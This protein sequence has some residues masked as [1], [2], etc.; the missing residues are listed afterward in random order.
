MLRWFAQTPIIQTHIEWPVSLSIDPIAEKLYW[1]DSK[2]KSISCADFQGRKRKVVHVFSDLRPHFIAIFGDFIFVTL[3][4]S[5]G[6]VRINKFSNFF[7][8]KAQPN[9]LL[10]RGLPISTRFSPTNHFEWIIRSL[11][12]PSPILILHPSMPQNKSHNCEWCT[13][14][15]SS[16]FCFYSND[17]TSCL[18][19]NN[20]E[21]PEK[22]MI[23]CPCNGVSCSG[24]E[25]CQNGVCICG[26]ACMEQK[27]CGGFNCTNGEVC[28]NG[29]CVCDDSCSDQKPV[30][31]VGVSALLGVLLTVLVV[32]F[33]WAYCFR[34]NS[35]GRRFV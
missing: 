11:S 14:S 24:A 4:R 16:G 1:S 15:S 6:V 21:Y 10:L 7:F 3:Y 31:A 5:N 2:R 13:D 8:D 29:V 30:L 25:I 26:K 20:P 28:V 18:C 34:Q 22:R 32:V 33:L 9:P 12:R 27:I 23:P 17:T 35:F 19:G